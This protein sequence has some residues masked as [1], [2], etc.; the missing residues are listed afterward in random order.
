MTLSKDAICVL[1]VVVRMVPVP[2]CHKLCM[3]KAWH[4]AKTQLMASNVLN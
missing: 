2:A 3:Q 1:A 4:V